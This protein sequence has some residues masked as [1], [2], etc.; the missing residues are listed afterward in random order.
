M[1]RIDK[2]S[3]LDSMKYV[4]FSAAGWNFPGRE[5]G[6]PHRPKAG[7]S[8]AATR[9]AWLELNSAQRAR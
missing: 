8:Y 5:A 7:T 6:T 2:Q 4:R 9:G 1:K 3:K